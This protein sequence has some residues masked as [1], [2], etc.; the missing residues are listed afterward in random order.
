MTPNR[1]S[2]ALVTAAIALAAMSTGCKKNVDPA[3]FDAGATT[4]A[5]ASAAPTETAAAVDPSASAAPLASLDPPK[6]V[7]APKAVAAK[8]TASAPKTIEACDKAKAICPNAGRA[9]QSQ[10]LA[11]TAECT[12]QGGH[13]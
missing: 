10:C 1:M 13:L 8:P 3:A 12:K 2:L 7:V 6:V 5:T 9:S 4:A 11:F